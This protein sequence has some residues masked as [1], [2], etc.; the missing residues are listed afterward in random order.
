[1]LILHTVSPEKKYDNVT[2]QHRQVDNVEIAVVDYHFIF[3]DSMDCNQMESNT[4]NKR[5]K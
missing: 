4:F 5:N 2:W 1:L 3:M